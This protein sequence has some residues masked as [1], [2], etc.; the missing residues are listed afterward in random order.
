M[1]LQ[2][3]TFDAAGTLGDGPLDLFFA[4]LIAAAHQRAN[5][6]GI[7]RA[8]RQQLPAG[9]GADLILGEHPGQIAE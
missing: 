8:G 7:H 4:D 1:S 9:G 2:A 3:I 6:L 5:I